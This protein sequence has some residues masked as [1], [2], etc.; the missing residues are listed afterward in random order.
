[1]SKS[2]PSKY[3]TQHLLRSGLQCPTKL[4]YK[5]HNYPE[6]KRIRP[7]LEHAG[8]NKH[9]LKKLAGRGYPG[10]IRVREA[11]PE[12]AGRR[13]AELLEQERVVIREAAFIDEDCYAKVPILVKEG[14]QVLLLDIQT[15]AFN[16]MKH[17]LVN[18][19]GTL[20]EKWKGYVTNMAFKKHL[21]SGLYPEWECSTLLLLPDKTARAKNSALLYHLQHGN[22]DLS[23]EELLWPIDISS[24]VDDMLAGRHFDEPFATLLAELKARYFDAQ[25]Q[26]PLLGK[27]C[28]NCEFRIAS[29]QVREGEPSGFIHCWGSAEQTAEYSELEQPVLDLI[30]AG[31]EKWMERGIY[32][33]K[34]VPLSELPDMRSVERQ[35][36]G[37][38]QKHRQSLQVRKTKGRDIPT[39]I[40]KQPIF[41]ELGRWTYPLHF[42]DF[43]AGNYAIPIREGQR[44]YHLVIFQYSCH[45]LQPDG[46]LSHH[47]WISEGRDAYPNYEMIRHLQNVPGIEE[48]TIVQYSNFEHYALK[49]IRKE[50][51]REKETVGDSNMLIEWL[52]G[53]V[54]RHD[55][56]HDAPP[57]LAD[58]SRLV[59]N[60]YYN[61]YMAN[62]LSIKDVLGSVLM[63]SDSLRERYSQ[64]YRSA[65]FEDIQWWQWDQREQRVKSPYKILREMQHA[66]VIGRG[67]EAMVVYGKLL[68]GEY[69]RSEKSN[70]MRALLK[71]CELDT[72][73]MVMI[74]QHWNSLAKR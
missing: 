34:N 6:D 69:S 35:G 56:N 62:S 15:K 45:T 68:A 43:E 32:L 18:H 67:T 49:T 65:N 33:Q 61:R 5:A 55:S 10:S 40:V 11:D 1:M 63:V 7:F 31:A 2:G 54:E 22:K 26:P 38:S 28:K 71:Y 3:F 42:L 50:L 17:E 44:P 24:H 74:V 25:W 60:Y 16:P 13:T 37:I 12:S 19:Q 41:R 52:D 47:Q 4:Y 72:L 30:G 57:Y 73:A 23:R 27:K 59:K 64:P 21:V 53:I 9:Q 39:E 20:H 36:S 48:G 70:I 29:S 51:M 8:F 58:L 14:E 66:A 46:D